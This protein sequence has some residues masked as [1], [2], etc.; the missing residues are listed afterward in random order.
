MFGGTMFDYRNN[1]LAG[2]PSPQPLQQNNPFNVSP[3]PP[4]TLPTNP[5][6]TTN[7][8]QQQQTTFQQDQTFPLNQLPPFTGNFITPVPMDMNS[9]QQVLP[10]TPSTTL[11]SQQLVQQLLTNAQNSFQQ[12]SINAIEPIEDFRIN[13][14][15]I[16]SLLNDGDFSS[17]NS[18]QQSIN[19]VS[20]TQD[21][22]EQYLSDSLSKIL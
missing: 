2:S 16:R 4:F 17:M 9:T 6:F 14:S 10:P 21:R 18:G 5:Q 20:R 3:Q 11:S 1:L 15:E 22:D 19:M 8:F 7:P 12:D 13:S